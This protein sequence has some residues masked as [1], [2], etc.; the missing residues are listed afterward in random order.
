MP[1]FGKGDILDQTPSTQ[2]IEAGRLQS[3]GQPDLHGQ[4]LYKNQKRK[5]E[6]E[7]KRK[8]GGPGNEGGRGDRRGGGSSPLV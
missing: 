5:E 4:T 1:D 2:E 6:S 8:K 7:R 3:Q